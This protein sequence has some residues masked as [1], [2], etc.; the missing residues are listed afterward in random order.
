MIAIY[1]NLTPQFSGR[2]L[3]FAARRVCKMKWR[4]CAAPAPSSHGPL[5]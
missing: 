4:T 3:L 5:Q 2:A 1:G